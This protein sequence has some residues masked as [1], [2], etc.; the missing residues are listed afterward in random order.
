[1]WRNRGGGRWLRQLAA[2]GP[3]WQALEGVGCPARQLVRERKGIAGGT[4][5]GLSLGLFR[6][7]ITSPKTSFCRRAAAW[8]RKRASSDAARLRGYTTY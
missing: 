1:M 8:S 3:F 5:F 7:V 4:R 2:A 6:V